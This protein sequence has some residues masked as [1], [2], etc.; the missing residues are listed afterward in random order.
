MY[1]RGHH[2]EIDLPGLRNDVNLYAFSRVLKYFLNVVFEG[3]IFKHC[4][5]F[6]GDQHIF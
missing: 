2:F 4:V 1:F 3:A 5:F 6:E